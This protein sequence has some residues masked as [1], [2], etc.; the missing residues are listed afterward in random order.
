MSKSVTNFKGYRRGDVITLSD[1]QTQKE[2]G[3][4]SVDFIIKNIRTYRE[5]NGFLTYTAYICEY[6]GK[7]DDEPNQIMIM[8]REVNDNYDL[9]FYFLE[10]DGDVTQFPM[11][12]T[13]EVVEEDNDVNETDT[14][15]TLTDDAF[16]YDE[17]YDGDDDNNETEEDEDDGFTED[18]VDRFEVE[19]DYCEEKSDVTWDKKSSGSTFGIEYNSTEDG[20]DIKTIAEYFTNDETHGNPHAFLEWTGDSEAGYVEIWYGCEIRPEDVEMFH[21]GK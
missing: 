1:I 10:A 5:P 4:M 19:I 2:F 15:E 8:V 7:D 20:K 21:S 3:E 13:K 17:D 11:L 9:M 18:L 12:F 14:N 16:S 6:Q